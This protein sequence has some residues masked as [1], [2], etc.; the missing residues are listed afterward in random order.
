MAIPFLLTEAVAHVTPGTT[1]QPL[2][3]AVDVLEY[4]VLDFLITAAF[5][6]PT[7]PS[8][9]VGL[10]SGMQCASS[11]NWILLSTAIGTFTA[12]GSAAASYSGGFFRYVRWRVTSFSGATS[13]NFTIE[14]VGR[15]TG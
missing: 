10:I 8:L 9:T 14:G 12:S 1:D 2:Y 11:D 4:D 6:A 15:K 7:T 3:T 13:A 5:E